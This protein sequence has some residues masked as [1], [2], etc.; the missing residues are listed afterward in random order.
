MRRRARPEVPG[1]DVAGAARVGALLR[2]RREMRGLTVDEVGRALRCGPRRVLAVEE[3]R[4]E[5]LPP[6]PYARGLIAAY[7][8]LVGVDAGALLRACGPACKPEVK[9]GRGI[10]L[11]PATERRSWRDWTVPIVLAGA[12]AAFVAAR[13]ALVPAP[14]RLEAPA[15]GTAV[16]APSPPMSPP[17]DPE[18]PPPERTAAVVPELRGVQVL[19]RSE[20]TTWIETRPDGGQPQRHELGPGENL[21]VGARGR[22]DLVLGDAGAVRLTVN[23]REL[24]FIGARGETKRGISFTPQA[25]ASGSAAARQGADVTVRPESGD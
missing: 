25:A 2:Q 7:A 4:F 23:G 10:F 11:R 15:A 3:G 24:G 16:F 18:P 14:A 6:H 21:E 17:P 5:D 1:A 19:I 8:N 20:G 22:L 12:V 13:S 9:E